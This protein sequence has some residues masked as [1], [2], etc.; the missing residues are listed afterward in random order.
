[1]LVT[2]VSLLRNLGCNVGRTVQCH[3]F[4]EIIANTASKGRGDGVVAAAAEEE[5]EEEEAKGDQQLTQEFVLGAHMLRYGKKASATNAVDDLCRRMACSHKLALKYLH[6]TA[7]KCLQ[8]QRQSLHSIL[9]YIKTMR[10]ANV[11]CPVLFMHRVSYD[12][13][14]LR[15]S[16]TV[17]TADSTPQTS[18][19]FVVESDWAALLQ[20]RSDGHYLVITGSFSPASRV[21]DGASAAATAVVLQTAAEAQLPGTEHVEDIFEKTVRIAETDEGPANEKAERLWDLYRP[22]SVLLHLLCVAHKIHSIVDRTWSLHS[23]VL[24]QV[25][26]TMLA[27]QSAVHLQRL[28]T[29][30]D[31][32]VSR[33]LVVLPLQPLAQDAVQFRRSVLKL[34]NHRALPPR[35]Q[36]V[37]TMAAAF[38]NGDWRCQDSLQHMCGNGCCGSRQ[39]SEQKVRKIL[40]KLFKT[41]RVSKLCKGNWAHWWV[42]LTGIGILQS[43]HGVLHAIYRAA[44]ANMK[45]LL[46][47]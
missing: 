24:S 5:E 13:T 42:P 38:L 20:Q 40:Q 39:D 47:T 18:K 32:H 27:Q 6:A 41:L 29:A 7:E 43:M 33:K 30:L 8:T 19:L 31:S 36:A 14:P 12:E 26:R 22:G 3:D 16:I 10:D 46:E 35:T 17:A 34:W 44:F 4:T 21:V 45:A 9:M 2:L 15:L 28:R 37:I 1:M 25:V 11:V 23:D